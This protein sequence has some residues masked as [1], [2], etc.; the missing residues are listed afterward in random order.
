MAKKTIVA[1]RAKKQ[2]KE[3]YPDSTIEER[4]DRLVALATNLAEQQ[5]L[6]GT[7]SAQ[8]I[9]HYLKLGSTKEK[10]NKELLKKQGNF[11]EA[12]TEAIKSA[13]ESEKIYAQALEAMRRYRSE[14]R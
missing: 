7:A 2:A 3:V 1:P 12:K 8:V 9:V 5:L 13:E 14:D 6:E 11:I 10:L 4:E